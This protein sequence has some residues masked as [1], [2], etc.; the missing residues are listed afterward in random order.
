MK[1]RYSERIQISIFLFLLI[2]V[3]VFHSFVLLG[4]IPFDIIWGGKLK[5]YSEV[6]S[7][8]II[9]IFINTMM[10][11]VVLTRAKIITIG[12]HPVKIKVILYTMSILFGVNSIGNLLADT[13]FERFVF[14]PI[15]L[16]FTLLS[17]QLARTK[18]PGAKIENT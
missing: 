5:K 3:I 1:K 14:T 10:L 16:L 12:N 13:S 15:T 2:A 17:W 9:S 7:L 11:I 18:K 8:E 6:M 4:I